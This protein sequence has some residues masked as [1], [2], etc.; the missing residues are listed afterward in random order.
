MNKD[1]IAPCG[2]NCAICSAYLR[3]KNKCHGCANMDS[4]QISFGRKCT[5]RNCETI[6]NNVSGFCYECSNFPCRRLRQIDK[7]YSSNYSV[8]ILENLDIIENEGIE[9]FLAREEEKWTC[10]ECGRTISCHAGFCHDCALEKRKSRENKRVMDEAEGLLI[11]PCG[12]NCG[13]CSSYLAMKYDLPGRGLRTSVC[14]GCRPR[15]RVCSLIIKRCQLLMSGEIE[16]CYECDEFPC[17]NLER[18]DKRYSEDFH[19]SMVENLRLLKEKGMA[20][21]LEREEE[22]WRC[23][24]CGGTISCH[25]GICYQCGVDKLR[26]KKD[27]YRWDD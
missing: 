17:A 5:V 23:P 13:V 18:L 1:L 20:A 4:Y 2:L 19:M 15:D 24:E 12:M 9:V 25:N 16:Y 22:E 27:K 26:E 10:P 7:R 11:A 8:S 3:E 6:K 14:R 21:L